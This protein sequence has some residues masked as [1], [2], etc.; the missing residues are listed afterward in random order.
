MLGE[1]GV[2]DDTFE[3]RARL[4]VAGLQNP[5]P[6]I[7]WS[8]LLLSAVVGWGAFAV[9]VVSSRPWLVVAAL[10]VSVILLYRGMCFACTDIINIPPGLLSG[11]ETVWN[12]LFGISLLLLS[13]MYVGVHQD[14]HRLATDGT[15][16]DPGTCH[17]RVQPS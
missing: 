17:S 8:D 11:F 4:A 9:A 12:L 7:F 14:H 5:K 15:N 3:S 2:S 10:F 1:I 6:S 13:Y 16:R